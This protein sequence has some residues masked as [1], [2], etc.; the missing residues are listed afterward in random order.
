M[1]VSVRPTSAE[2]LIDARAVFLGGATTSEV[3]SVVDVSLP[4]PFVPVTTTRTYEPPS[5]LARRYVESVAPAMSEQ[6]AGSESSL[7]RRHWYVMVGAGTP[8]QVPLWAVSV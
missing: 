1:A 5:A 7:H 2:P 8:V 4:D 6:S 3:A